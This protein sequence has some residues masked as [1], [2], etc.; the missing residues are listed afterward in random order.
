MKPKPTP[1]KYNARPVKNQNGQVVGT[2]RGGM[3]M[4]KMSKANRLPMDGG[5][6]SEVGGSGWLELNRKPRPTSPEKPGR[7]PPPFIGINPPKTPKPIMPEKPGRRPGKP[8]MTIMPVKPGRPGITPLPRN[9]G[10]PDG[11]YGPRPMPT[12]TPRPGAR[13]MGSVNKAAG[14]GAFING[15]LAPQSHALTKSES[16]PDCGGKMTKGMCKNMCKGMMH[17][18]NTRAKVQPGSEGQMRQDWNA[19]VR[20]GGAKNKDTTR[21]KAMSKGAGM[22]KC[23]SGMSKSMCK[24]GM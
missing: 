13:G 3:G 21:G 23:G 14:Q 22:C 19:Y 9:P 1:P 24:C 4:G 20:V 17:K 15:K 18:A 12:D 8:D 5:R 10:S 16:C 6:L 2:T 7:R 11:K